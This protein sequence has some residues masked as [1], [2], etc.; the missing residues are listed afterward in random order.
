MLDLQTG[1][2]AFFRHGRLARADL[3][4]HRMSGKGSYPQ[5]ASEGLDLTGSQSFSRSR[6][7]ALRFSSG[8]HLA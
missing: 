3:N 4:K 8:V 7:P 5:S 6:V 1:E 2:G